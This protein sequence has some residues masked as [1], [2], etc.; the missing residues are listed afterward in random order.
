MASLI[1]LGLPV[2]A[3]VVWITLFAPAPHAGPM[4]H[5]IDSPRIELD[6]SLRRP[7]LPRVDLYGNEI[8]DAVREYR[9]GPEGTLYE[10]SAGR[11]AVSLPAP[12]T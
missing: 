5:G 10:R 2:G 8:D 1:R 6:T 4:T 9:V 3:C 12:S 7:S 11:A